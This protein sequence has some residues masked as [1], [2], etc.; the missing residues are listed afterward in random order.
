MYVHMYI[1]TYSYEDYM[2]FRVE[3]LGFP[4]I[5]ATFLGVPMIRI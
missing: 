5:R 2:G 4:K 1:Y 3:G